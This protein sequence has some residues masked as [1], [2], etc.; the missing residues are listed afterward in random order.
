M[1]GVSVLKLID[2]VSL[3]SM[4]YAVA[5]ALFPLHFLALFVF[6]LGKA[7]DEH[8]ES[9]KKFPKSQ[10]EDQ[11]PWLYISYLKL[12]NVLEEAD[13]FFGCVT[14]GVIGV[15]LVNISTYILNISNMAAIPTAMICSI[16]GL[17]IYNFLGY[18]FFCTYLNE[19]SRGVEAY[20]HEILPHNG[21]IFRWVDTFHRKSA[22]T[23]WGLTIGKF[24]LLERTAF[25]GLMSAVVT[26]L[27][28][29]GQFAE[30]NPPI[31]G[32]A[33]VDVQAFMLESRN[34]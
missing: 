33:I 13:N 34:I 24:F 22:D 16:V 11:L 20:L 21:N 3:Y 1:S 32:T 26:F 9:L 15:T 14:L 31:N 30:S 18:T 12:A 28:L 17:M 19:K 2:Y 27:A 25:I 8:L 23:G 29:Y 5:V 6:F 7:F 4:V 10:L